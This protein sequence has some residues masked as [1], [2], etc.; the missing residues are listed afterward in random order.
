MEEGLRRR[1]RSRENEMFGGGGKLGVVRIEPE[2]KR[3]EK[4]AI[5]FPQVIFFVR[6]TTERY[7][8]LQS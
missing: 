5:R 1:R 6:M 2:R 7:R 4:A 8:Q 3:N